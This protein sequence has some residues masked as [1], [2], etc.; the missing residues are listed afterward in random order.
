MNKKVFLSIVLAVFGT[1]VFSNSVFAYT[2]VEQKA[3]GYG[4]YRCYN[5]LKEGDTNNDVVIGEI[6]FRGVQNYKSLVLSNSGD[7]DSAIALPT[8]F[9]GLHRIENDSNISCRDLFGGVDYFGSTGFAGLL[10]SEKDP[11]NIE[12]KK[13]LLNTLSYASQNDGTGGSGQC[14]KFKYTFGSLGANYQWQ[15]SDGETAAVCSTTGR[16]T[17]SD[18]LFDNNSDSVTNFSLDGNTLTMNLWTLNTSTTQMGGGYSTTN[19]IY[20][21]K[22]YTLSNYSSFTALSDAV[23]ADYSAY[24]GRGRDGWS[25]GSPNLRIRNVKLPDHARVNFPYGERVGTE[26]E[27]SLSPSREQASLIAASNLLGGSFNNVQDLAFLAEEEYSLYKTYFDDYY[28]AEFQCD[29]GPG[30]SDTEDSLKNQGYSKITGGSLDGCYAKPTQNINESVYGLSESKYFDGTKLDFKKLINAYSKAAEAA[31]ISKEDMATSTTSDTDGT[32]GEVEPTCA[33]SGGAESLGWI[34]CPVL[35]W[36]KNAATEVYENALEPAL[37]VEPKLFTESGRGTEQAWSFF[38]G[39]A[40]TLFVILFLF[41]IFSQLTGVG[42]DN[43]GI[44]KIMPKL[45][46]VA[47]LINLSYLIC[48]ICVD[49]SNIVGNGLQNLFDSLPTGSPDA[50]VSAALGSGAGATAI[51]AVILLAGLGGGALVIWKNPA[52]LISLLVGALGVVI[53]IFFVFVLLAA[54]EAAIIVLTVL[55]PLAFACYML[56]NT[57]IIFDKWLKFWKGLLLLYPI[58]GALI[59]GGNFVSNLLLSAGIATQGF[60]SALTA[61]LVGIIP[62]FFIPIALKNAFAA[63]G[64]IGSKITGFGDKMRGGVTRGVRNSGMYKNL[65]ERGK[66]TG[67]RRRAGY[68]R[69]GNKKELNGFQRFIRGGSRNVR[70]NALAYQKLQAEKGAL[71]ATEGADYMLATETANEAKRI[72]SSGEINTIGKIGQGKTLTDGL[73]RALIDNNRAKIN[74]YSDALSAKGENGRK[75]VKEAYDRAVKD[76]MDDVAAKTLADNIMANHAADYKNNNRSMFNVAQGINSGS[77]PAMPID[78]YV[79]T[80]QSDL[81]NKVTAATIGTMD[82]DAFDET[83]GIRRDANGNITYGIPDGADAATIGEIAYKAMSTQNA[84]IKGDRMAKLKS[85]MNASGYS[86]PEAQDVNVTNM[87]KTVAIPGAAEE[88]KTFDV[89]AMS[90]ETL[91]DMATNPNVSNDDQTRIA[92]E[93][94]YLRRNNG[95]A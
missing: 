39:M 10:G 76:N 79:A 70:R 43:Y 57:K 29:Y 30:Q 69:N 47:V 31:S 28:A 40:N 24:Y 5:Y 14:F 92:A 93:Q 86:G 17:Q 16:V 13:K 46:V 55:S 87:P 2:A 82:D 21:K 45:V 20:D 91:L 27:Y 78:R 58:C 64:T 41:V 71:K 52:I 33:N 38:Q 88:G 66:E 48:V 12:D 49:L 60:W 34:V 18:I 85:V 84:G 15:T 73:Y 59:G 22:T 77:N 35:N 51:T 50:S 90:D 83:F 67:I 75:A 3:L 9:D 56:P 53:A 7:G 81:A 61:M 63:M 1:F 11:Q 23:Y 37:Q 19:N 4:V 25:G 95:K 8:G 62:I 32:N 6:S 89:R 44:K 65:Q 74:A 36:L 26:E 80:H 68:D 54:R 72:V 42:I 94:E